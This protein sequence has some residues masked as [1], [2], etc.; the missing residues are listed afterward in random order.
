VAAEFPK[1]RSEFLAKVADLSDRQVQTDTVLRCYPPG[2]PPAKIV[3][4]AGQVVFLY[5]DPN[6][7]FFRIIPT[8]GRPHRASLSSSYLGDA[9]GRFEGDTRRSI[10]RMRR[11]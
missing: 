8:D 4:T 5:D 10:S 3:Q 6:G 2:V 9:V 1:Y 11:G 7:S